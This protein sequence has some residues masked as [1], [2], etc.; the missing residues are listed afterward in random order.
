MTS[1]QPHV[2]VVPEN[3][4]DLLADARDTRNPSIAVVIPVYNGADRLARVLDGL[5]RQSRPPDEIVVADDGSEED[6]AGV[7]DR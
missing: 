5:G 2:V 6:I 7:V 1:L 4:Y 3:R